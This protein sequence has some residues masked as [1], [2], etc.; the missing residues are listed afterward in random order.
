M[1][2]S[3]WL[4]LLRRHE[5]RL[6]GLWL[7]LSVLVLGSFAVGPVRGQILG[8]VARVADWWDARWDRRLAAGE[9]MVTEGKFEEAA[10]YLERLDA[11]FPARTSRHARDRDREHLLGLLARTQESLGRSGR[12]MAAWSRLVAF[13][14]LNYRNHFGYAQA[15]ERLLSGWALA[16]EARDG[17]ARALGLFPSHLPSLRGYLDYYMDRG[18]FPAVRE[19]YQAYLDAF[20]VSRLAIRGGEAAEISTVLV[21]GRSHEIEVSLAPGERWDGT[22]SISAGPYPLTVEELFI[23]PAMRVGE[24]LVA[25]Y[26]GLPS[27]VPGR[28]TR[29]GAGW[30]PEDSSANWLVRVPDGLRD[31]GT[32]RL[33]V[34]VFKFIDEALWKQVATSYRNLL[35]R[36]GLVEA[37]QRT[38]PFPTA[39]V[40]DSAFAS[41]DW[42]S[43]GPFVPGRR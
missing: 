37:G 40:A 5:R 27:P 11:V 7:G 26:H 31:I 16:P 43:D 28:M 35:D 1:A 29:S 20:L 34:R 33:R 17:Y 42:M 22:I 30:I 21:D 12:A 14:S 41:L 15:A 13:D 9:R 38:A 10:G 6:A 32:L 19:A 36:G 4:G 24:S 8:N 3:A 2:A 25:E 18:E 39:A 23:R